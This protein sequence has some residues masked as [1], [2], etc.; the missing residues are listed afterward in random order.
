[1]SRYDEVYDFM[2]A[3]TDDVDDIMRFYD[4][5]WP[6]NKLLAKDKDFLIWMFGLPD[7]DRLTFVIAR[8][9]KSGKIA[10]IIGYVQQDP[11]IE[12][13]DIFGAAVLAADDALPMLGTEI[14]HRL[15][16]MVPFRSYHSIGMHEDSTFILAK[17]IGKKRTGYL[18][19]YYRLNENLD[20]YRIAVV[21]HKGI[22]VLTQTGILRE[23]SSFSDFENAYLDEHP[24]RMP[25]KSLW[26]IRHR[27]YDHPVYKYHLVGI[28]VDG[29]CPAFFVYRIVEVDGSKVVRI[30]DY[31]GNIEHIRKVGSEWD[32]IIK[33][34]GAEYVDFYCTGIPDEIMSSVGFIKREKDD[35]NIIPNW[36][37]PFEQKNIEISFATYADEGIVFCRSDA[38]MDRPNWGYY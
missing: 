14:D 34:Y 30:V 36:F 22:P 27:F 2:L 8:E 18:D 4:A 38:E 32:R 21:N 15:T 37:E 26:Y 23:F 24:E 29:R 16:S 17:R 5:Y 10:A 25:H 11:V 13:A 28:D 20:S 1:M 12:Q 31:T 3:K 19:H 33:D 35:T 7:S 9:R 6:G